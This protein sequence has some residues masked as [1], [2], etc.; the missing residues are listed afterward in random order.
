M[1]QALV[2]YW[3]LSFPEFLLIVLALILLCGRYTGYRLT[4]LYRFRTILKGR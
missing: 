4:E 2:Q 1:I 3:V